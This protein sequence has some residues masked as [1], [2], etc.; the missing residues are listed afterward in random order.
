VNSSGAV[1][2]GT[3]IYSVEQ[4]AKIS[5]LPTNG[6]VTDSAWS[7]GLAIVSST[8]GEVKTFN[9]G[10]EVHTF[11]VHAGEANALAV[12]P[13]EKILASVGVDKSIV[14]YDISG[15]K[16]LNRVFSDSAL[17]TA[18]FHPDGHIFAAG[19]TDGQIKLFHTTTGA[20]A[21][22]FDCGG[23]VQALKFS[24]N[25]TWFGAVA[26]G[27]TSVVIFDLRKEGQAAKVKELDT[28]SRVDAISWDYTGAFLATAGPSGITV[29][30]YTKSSKAWSVPLTSATPAVAIEWGELAQ[31]LICVSEGGELTVLGRE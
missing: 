17:T 5:D 8:S 6:K 22:S 28:G 12:H 15:G 24:E 10:R 14:F 20:L 9:E 27:S 18:A 26:K 21:T 2:V 11:R 23:P 4:D 1:I 3:S 25:G 29:Q 7:N 13:S 16:T 31:K 19:G 30:Q